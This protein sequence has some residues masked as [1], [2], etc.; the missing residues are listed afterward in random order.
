MLD[1]SQTLPKLCRLTKKGVRFEF[2]D[3]QR[4]A[5]TEFKKRLSS[6]EILGYFDK[7]AKTLII[8]DASPVGLGAVLIEENHQL[9]E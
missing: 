2:E 4:K 3:K 1:L 5:F 9:C 7:D 8:T 6:A